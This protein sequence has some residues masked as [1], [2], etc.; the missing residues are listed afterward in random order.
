MKPSSAATSDT[1]NR[2][3]RRSQ[4]GE[5]KT[6]MLA[7]QVADGGR[8]DQ[9]KEETKGNEHS[10]TTYFVANTKRPLVSS[11]GAENMKALQAA[12]T[13]GLRMPVESAQAVSNVATT[14]DSST[15][16]DAPDDSSPGC[17]PDAEDE[18]DD[19]ED[20]E[21]VR[22]T[23]GG[24]IIVPFPFK[25]HALLDD[26]EANGNEDIV[27]FFPNGKAF[28]IHK[29]KEFIKERTRASVL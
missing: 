7:A 26:A 20:Y 13:G 9:D 23:K 24:K 14:S 1:H 18:D 27:S 11:G 6:K 15:K 5:D 8:E 12:N 22:K 2:I 4:S 10:T 3:Q 19:V 25:L 28:A 21:G 17:M 16:K 29:P